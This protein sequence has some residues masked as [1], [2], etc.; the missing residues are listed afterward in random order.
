MHGLTRPL[1]A[2]ALLSA[3]GP[4]TDTSDSTASTTATT[5][6][7]DPTTPSTDATDSTTT[8][9]VTTTTT[10][11][12]TTTTD[13]TTTDPL[14]TTTTTDSSTTS[15]DDPCDP[16]PVEDEPCSDEGTFCNSGCQDQC[17]FCNILKCENG[18][19]TG[20]EAPPAPCLGCDELCNYT[21]VPMCAGGPPDLETCVAGCNDAMAGPCNIEFSALRA[22]AG[23]SPTFTCDAMTRPLVAGCESQFEAFY[24]C[25]DL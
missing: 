1:L 15:V 3:C 25:S 2:L 18:A 20:L 22:C 11:S 19:W 24:A 9:P 8:P 7:T 5:T 16:F 23:P 17:S 13:P 6:A 10:D 21:V 4:G 14:T 12:P